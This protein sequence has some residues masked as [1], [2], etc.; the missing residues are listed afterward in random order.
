MKT[1]VYIYCGS[2]A[3]CEK[4]MK[5]YGWPDHEYIYVGKPSYQYLRGR[6]NRQIFFCGSWND[7]DDVSDCLRRAKDLGWN[8]DFRYPP[9]YE[10]RITS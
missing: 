4:I 6:R 2:L 5:H 1:P 8:A 10:N 9:R 7:R 3:E